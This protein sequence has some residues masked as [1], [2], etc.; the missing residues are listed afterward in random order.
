MGGLLVRPI[1]ENLCQ[2]LKSSVG[3]K[4]TKF[5]K[6]GYGIRPQGYLHIIQPR[7]I[8][9]VADQTYLTTYKIYKEGENRPLMVDQLVE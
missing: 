4:K 9:M 5:L 7:N 8:S 2:S 3:P 1:L 6:D